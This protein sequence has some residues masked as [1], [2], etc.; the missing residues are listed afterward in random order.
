MIEQEPERQRDRRPQ[1]KARLLL[2]LPYL[3]ALGLVGLALGMALAW[4]WE[5]ETAILLF[6]IAIL[7]SAAYGGLASG[8][9]ATLLSA[10]AIAYFLLPPRHTLPLSADMLLRLAVFTLVAVVI[11][12]LTAARRQSYAEL[13]RRVTARTAELEQV[14]RV[15]ERNATHQAAV[16]AFGQQALAGADLD[17]L[18]AEV[19]ELVSRTLHAEFCQVIEM[20][21]GSRYL[22]HSR[23]DPDRAAHIKRQ[24]PEAARPLVEYALRSQDP[25]VIA[26]AREEAGLLSALPFLVESDIVSAVCVVIR[27]YRPFGLLLVGSSRPRAFTAED[28]AYLQTLAHVLATALDRQE[29]ER[30]SLGQ[31][32]ALVSSLNAL[33][34]GPDLEVFLAQTLASLIEH[35]NASS[36]S[37]WLYDPSHARFHPVPNRGRELPGEQDHPPQPDSLWQEMLRSRR[38]VVIENVAADPRLAARD[39]WAAQG[40]ATLVLVPMLLGAEPTGL[41]RVSSLEPRHYRMEEMDLAQ[42]LAQQATLA[43]QASRQAEQQ[44]QTAMIQERNRMAREIHDTLAQAFTGIVIQMEAAEAALTK[45]SDQVPTF[46]QRAREL[47][48]Q[49]LAEARRSVWALRPQ[50]LEEGSLSNALAQQVQ[51]MTTGAPVRATFHLRGHARPL[52][53]EVEENL[54]RIGQEAVTNALRHARAGTIRVELDFEPQVVCLRIRDDGEG[55]DPQRPLGGNRFGLVGMRERTERIE[56]HLAIHSRPGEGTE[57]AVTVP[58][59]TTSEEVRP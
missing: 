25:V 27:G 59:S 17:R 55:F 56:G 31:T 48:R 2:A 19:L 8:L 20:Q 30:I 35:L 22:T 13:E 40:A 51:Q 36:A 42:A 46:I 45:R 14:N 28:G 9:F 38:P 4:P 43:I 18:V 21:A 24:P 3:L 32:A 47:A 49:G 34:V 37:L 44:Q 26:D 11:S 5:Q 10:L 39:W 57:I 23:E 54:L 53:P 41:L 12:A 58:Y 1:R 15:L 29:A 16:A 50:A 52:S 6:L 7:V 33:G